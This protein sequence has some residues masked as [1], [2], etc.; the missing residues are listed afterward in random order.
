M[1][2]DLFDTLKAV[3]DEHTFLDFARALRADRGTADM[4]TPTFDGL[5]DEWANGSIADFLEAGIAWA[6]D[7][8]FGAR[9]GPKPANPWASFAWFL[10]AGRG[11][12]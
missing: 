6:E 5:P 4:S 1:M 9:P 7:S 10:W 12:E 3:H 11:Y 8:A 2:S